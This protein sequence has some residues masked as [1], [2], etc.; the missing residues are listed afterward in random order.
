MKLRGRGLQKQ[1]SSAGTE[2]KSIA[3]MSSICASI[4]CV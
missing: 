2:A 1:R 3:G 4:A